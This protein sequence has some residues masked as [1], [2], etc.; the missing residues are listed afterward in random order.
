[1]SIQKL[2]T[3]LK[4]SLLTLTI[5]GFTIGMTEFL[6]MGV[7]PDMAASLKITIPTAGHLISIYAM[8]VV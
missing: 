8:G 4:P 6:I 5:G 7:L 3:T 2:F 1:M